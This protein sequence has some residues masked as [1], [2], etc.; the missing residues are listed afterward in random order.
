MKRARS[1]EVI[2]GGRVRARRRLAPLLA[3]AAFA[4]LLFVS[5]KL[6]G[7]GPA[8]AGERRFEGPGARGGGVSGYGRITGDILRRRHHEAAGGRRRWGKLANS[9]ELERMAAQA[10]ALGAAAWGE[11]SASTDDVDPIVPRDGAECPASLAVAGEAAAFL[12]CG[13]AA[14]SAVTVVG[15]PHPARPEYVEAVERSGDGNGTVMVAQFAVELRGLRTSDADDPPR[16][17]H[18][19]PRLRGDWSGRPVLEMN[20]C[21][22]MQWG[23]A[24]RCDGNPSDDDL[25]GTLSTAPNC[26]PI[27]PYF[28]NAFKFLLLFN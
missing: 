5:V 14:G 4:Y 6:A 28:A 19:N 12:P 13:L 7:L 22:R 26:M 18:L 21:F 15:T 20:T 10:W 25:N 1:S 8:G 24:Q 2:L 16:I 27:L 3:A 17:L 9:T 11:A 23:R